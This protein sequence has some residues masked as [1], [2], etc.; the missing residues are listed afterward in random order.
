[1]INFL[2]RLYFDS[3]FIV[4]ILNQLYNMIFKFM[5]KSSFEKKKTS[6]V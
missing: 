1:M 5:P 2:K 4:C 3:A 6:F